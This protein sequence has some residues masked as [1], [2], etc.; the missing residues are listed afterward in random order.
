[1]EYHKIIKLLDN[2]PN[3]QTKL[4]IKNRVEINNGAHGMYNTNSQIQFKTSVLN[5]ICLCD[6]SDAYILVS[7]SKTVP[8]SKPK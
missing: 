3:Q 5:V 7:G 2:T 6:N 1:M 8:N 4:R